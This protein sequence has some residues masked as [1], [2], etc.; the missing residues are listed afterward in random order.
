MCRRSTHQNQRFCV[1]IS[2][3]G[4]LIADTAIFFKPI[5]E[6]DFEFWW[7]TR[8]T[9]LDRISKEC[10]ITQHLC[11]VQFG[12][13]WYHFKMTGAWFNLFSQ[14]LWQLPKKDLLRRCGD[15]LKVAAI[16]TATTTMT[17]TFFIST[18]PDLHHQGFW[19][20]MQSTRYQLPTPHLLWL[21]SAEDLGTLGRIKRRSPRGIGTTWRPPYVRSLRYTPMAD[22][23]TFFAGTSIHLLPCYKNWCSLQRIVGGGGTGM[24]IMCVELENP[25]LAWNLKCWVHFTSWLM[26]R[27]IPWLADI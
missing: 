2:E 18:C 17:T 25:S 7:R 11:F 26:E 15:S 13:S 5:A 22:W 24:R 3:S 19:T 12:T 6:Q 16:S 27:C 4:V 21:R 20:I 9:R 14:G 23:Q 8:F 10:L 1:S